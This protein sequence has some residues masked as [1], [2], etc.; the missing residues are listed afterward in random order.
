MRSGTA[1]GAAAALCAAC[2]LLGLPRN[3][4]AALDEPA[5]SVD[6]DQ[7]Q[8]KARRLSRAQNGYT[9]QEMTLPSGTVVREFVSPATGRVFA[10][11]WQ[12]PFMPDL[13]QLLGAHF[14]TFTDAAKERPP[15]RGALSVNRPELVVHSGGHMRAFSGFAY[16]PSKLPE[17]VQVDDLH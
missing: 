2:M 13:K 3:A 9:V 10:V 1:I 5:S 14:S 15:H 16:L 11:A 8:M 7:A 12:G 6:A 17:G 4:A